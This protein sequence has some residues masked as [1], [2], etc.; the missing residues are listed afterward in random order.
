MSDLGRKRT[1]ERWVLGA[2]YT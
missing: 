1:E 2:L